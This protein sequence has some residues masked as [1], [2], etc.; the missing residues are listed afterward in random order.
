MATQARWCD[1]ETR[2]ARAYEGL[3]LDTQAHLDS[4]RLA[5]RT[6]ETLPGWH[7]GARIELRQYSVEGKVLDAIGA[8]DA[9]Y[10]R[11]LVVME[12]GDFQGSRPGDFYRASGSNWRSTT[13]AHGREQRRGTQQAIQRSP[14]PR[15]PLR[16]VLE[17]N[18]LRKPD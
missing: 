4:Q 9:A 17:D 7:R 3:H 18:P 14:L 1:Q 13:P 12:S 15:D 5:L 10:K 8:P 2:V 16:T 11:R 6:L